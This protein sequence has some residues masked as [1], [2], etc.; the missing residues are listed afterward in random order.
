MKEKIAEI[1][2]YFKSFNKDSIVRGDMVG[3]LY[4]LDEA[5]SIIKELEAENIK[6]RAM[7]T[8]LTDI[9]RKSNLRSVENFHE[10]ITGAKRS[11]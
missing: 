3:C 7:N 8:K 5:L 9:A 11:V 6:L 2:K 4:K 10:A 1:D